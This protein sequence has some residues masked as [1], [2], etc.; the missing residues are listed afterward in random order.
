MNIVFGITGSLGA[1]KTSLAVDLQSYWA[2]QGKQLKIIE[3]DDVRR[4][5]LWNSSQK[6]HIQLRKDLAKKLN[7]QSETEFHWLNRKMFTE[8]IFSSREML[9]VYAEIATPIFIADIEKNIKSEDLDVVIV[10]AHLL[11][12]NYDVLLNSSVIITDC[13]SKTVINRL[14]PGILKGDDLSYQELKK[15][16]DLQSNTQ[17]C[18][19]LAKNKNISFI[20]QNTESPVTTNDLSNLFYSISN[21]HKVDN[22]E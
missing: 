14:M 9:D 6:H 17:T 18:L 10:W 13:L 20:L 15:R 19:S 5:A 11:E 21:N 3:L 4:Y 16:I 2:T 8:L 12:E 7:I 22:N 1:G